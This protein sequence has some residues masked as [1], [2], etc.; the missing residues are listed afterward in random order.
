MDVKTK[1]PAEV[2]PNKLAFTFKGVKIYVTFN[3]HGVAFVQVTSS[4]LIKNKCPYRHGTCIFFTLSNYLKV[5]L[6]RT[7][8]HFSGHE[9]KDHQKIVL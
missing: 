1:R 6:H 4:C 5:I 2:K 7:V 3:K 9:I 8:T